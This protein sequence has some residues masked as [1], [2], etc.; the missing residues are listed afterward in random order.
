MTLVALIAGVLNAGALAAQAASPAQTLRVGTNNIYGVAAT[1]KANGDDKANGF[2]FEILPFLSVPQMLQALNAGEIEVAEVGEVGP[3]IA[4]AAGI[5][6]KT[7]AATR[8]WP[9]GEAIIVYKTSP[10]RTLADLKGKKVSYPRA[11]NAQWLLTKALRKIGL[12]IGDV[13]STDVPAGTNLFAVLE[14]GG[15]DASVFIDASLSSYEAQGARRILNSGDA[16]C[17]N[18]LFFIATE[19]AVA[20]KP[21]SIAAFVRQLHRHLDWASRNQ[22]K[23]AAAVAD[24]LKIDPAIALAVERK[25]PTDL[26]PIDQ[27]LIT[28]G[29]DIAD[30][31]L[32]QGVIPK[33]IKV[34]STFTTQ[35]NAAI[36][37]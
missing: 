18:S 28:N 4:Q 3:V 29:Q 6:I 34:E 22:E 12:T 37:E 19:T 26:R 17:D 10:I 20:T 31:F 8:P 21:E 11:T 15:V 2:E 36:G 25:R 30:T 1:F 5:P 16:D 9:E 23:R 32:A 14:T 13:V 35:F 33:P 27:A 7:I 24:L